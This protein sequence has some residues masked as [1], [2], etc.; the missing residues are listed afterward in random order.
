MYCNTRETSSYTLASANI[1]LSKKK[2][3]QDCKI[4]AE[5]LS[6]VCFYDS[7]ISGYCSDRFGIGHTCHDDNECVSGYCDRSECKPSRK[8]GES[9]R[10]TI[11]SPSLMC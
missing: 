3:N 6:G 1:C 4:D 11:K 2:N 5:C 8:E 9:C 10:K 7:G